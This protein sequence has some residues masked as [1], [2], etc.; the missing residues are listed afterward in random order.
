MTQSVALS[1]CVVHAQR[2]AAALCLGCKAFYCRECV[3]EHDGRVLCSRCIAAAS[4]PRDKSA[5]I[6]FVK[7]SMAALAGFALLWLSFYYVGAALAAWT[8]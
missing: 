1:R 6:A 5:A 3:T 4:K 7:L 2:E 8:R